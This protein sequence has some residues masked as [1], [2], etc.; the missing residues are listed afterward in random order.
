MDPEMAFTGIIMD[1]F[2]FLG[3]FGCKDTDTLIDTYPGKRPSN[4]C[5]TI[6]S[7]CLSPKMNFVR[8]LR[9]A[10]LLGSCDTYTLPTGPQVTPTR[11]R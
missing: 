9:S 2:L 4:Y 8:L 7:I 5:T 10:I 1:Y 6:P 3:L 11:L